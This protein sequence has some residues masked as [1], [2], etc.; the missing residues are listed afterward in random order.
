MPDLV[1]DLTNQVLGLRKGTVRL[2]EHDRRWTFVYALIA[3]EISRVTGIRDERIQH[4]GSTS[5]EGLAA[6]PT[7]DIVVGVDDRKSVDSVAEH[8]VETGFIDRGPGEGS[9]GHLLVRESAPGVRIVHIHIVGYGTQD[10]RNCVDFRD[11]L[12]NDPL[13]RDQYADVKRTL[14]L[15]FSDDRKSYRSAKDAFIRKTLQMLSDSGP[16]GDS[17]TR[18]ATR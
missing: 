8:L 3:S 2:A 5:V 12:R 9:I 17:E 13:A 4:V 16:E 18:S 7:L 6:K 14:A 15:R 10:W 11:G 1:S